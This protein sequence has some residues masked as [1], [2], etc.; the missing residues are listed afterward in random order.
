VWD[1]ICLFTEFVVRYVCSSLPVG[2]KWRIMYAADEI[3]S[4]KDSSVSQLISS[5]DIQRAT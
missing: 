2:K 4:S 5:Q 1:G 3:Q